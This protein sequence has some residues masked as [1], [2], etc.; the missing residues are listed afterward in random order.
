MKNCGE[1]NQQAAGNGQTG[2]RRRG[3]RAIGT[4]ETG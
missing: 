1:A 4:G 3:D 2:K